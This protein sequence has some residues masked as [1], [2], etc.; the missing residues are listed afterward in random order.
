MIK[1]IMMKKIKMNLK[2]NRKIKD[3]V[4]KK[5]GKEYN[6]S[7]AL[8]KNLLINAISHIFDGMKEQEHKKT[9]V[10]AGKHISMSIYTLCTALYGGVSKNPLGDYNFE[11]MYLN[12]I[13]NEMNIT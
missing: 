9:S 7:A 3:G 4:L 2:S 5:D 11:N 1:M 12:N 6:I 10:F 13:I 8:Y